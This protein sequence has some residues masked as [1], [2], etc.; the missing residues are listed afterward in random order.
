MQERDNG[1]TTTSRGAA[2]YGPLGDHDSLRE[3]LRHPGCA[4]RQSGSRFTARQWRQRCLGLLAVAA[5]MALAQPVKAACSIMGTVT[6]GTSGDS[7][8]N[9]DVYCWDM[10]TTTDENGDYEFRDLS[11]GTY[12]LKI[13]YVGDRGYVRPAPVRLA[14]PDGTVATVD[15]VLQRAPVKVAFDVLSPWGGPRGGRQEVTF[16]LRYHMSCNEPQDLWVWAWDPVAEKSIMLFSGPY[17]SAPVSWDEYWDNYGEGKFTTVRWKLSFDW[18]TTMMQN[19]KFEIRS[20]AT[21]GNVFDGGAPIQL[22]APP[23]D[24]NA[25]G[26]PGGTTRTVR[27]LNMVI[28]KY[29]SA[30][31][32]RDFFRYDPDG[33][34]GL[35]APTVTF[36]VMDADPDWYE[37]DARVW[38]SHTSEWR[39]YSWCD[40]LFWPYMGMTIF[41]PG[42]YSLTWDGSNPGYYGAGES[43]W[44]TYTYD[45]DL[46]KTGWWGG[47]EFGAKSTTGSL[48]NYATYVGDHCVQWHQENPAGPM[49]LRCSYTIRDDAGIAPD[50]IRLI[51]VNPNLANRGSVSAPPLPDAP[52][53]MHDNDA[54][55]TDDEPGP[56]YA[57]YSTSNLNKTTGPW[58]VVITGVAGHGEEVRRDRKNPRILAA[59]QQPDPP[60][61]LYVLL[62]TQSGSGPIVGASAPAE[63]PIK[64]KIQPALSAFDIVCVVRESSNMFLSESSPGGRSYSADIDNKWAFPTQSKA[65]WFDNENTQTRHGRGHFVTVFDDKDLGRGGASLKVVP[66]APAQDPDVAAVSIDFIKAYNGPHATLATRWAVTHAVLHEIGHM[67]GAK[68]H[69]LAGTTGNCAMNYDGDGGGEKG[70]GFWHAPSVPAHFYG[71]WWVASGSEDFKRIWNLF[72]ECKRRHWEEVR[73][74]LRYP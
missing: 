2:D 37:I 54:D 3:R 25:P 29:N 35:D 72:G 8:A 30:S 22:G 13:P 27:L 11:A 21:F 59:N 67:A 73:S 12:K 36:T 71:K 46:C 65:R 4:G 69:D 17:W 15:F 49:E 45:I 56:G 57:V 32:N 14:V 61:I 51:A 5:F 31:G 23:V 66:S 34:A 18:Y 26:T 53:V 68:H 64:Q 41:G 44:G 47:D 42:D 60:Q 20:A 10:W 1:F 74:H 52:N 38:M 50:S 39:F 33:G 24:E 62:N 9:V 43:E 7:V 19:G 63:R 58:R 28:K 55:T 6:D 48:C 40:M 70:D 16:R